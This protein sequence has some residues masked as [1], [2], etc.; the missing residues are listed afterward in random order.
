MTYK[1]FRKRAQPS[2]SAAARPVETE[3]AI[4]TEM[5]RLYPRLGEQLNQGRRAPRLVA[6]NAHPH[7]FRP[8]VPAH[9]R[10]FFWISPASRAV[11]R[12]LVTNYTLSQLLQYDTAITKSW[13]ASTRTTYGGA[14]ADWIRWCDTNS[15]PES[16]RLPINLQDLRMYIADKVGAEGEAKTSNVLAGLQA[17]HTIQ[18]VPWPNGDK[19]LVGL[20]RAVTTNA[21]ASTTR[22]PRPPITTKHL[23]AI[24]AETKRNY[25]P[26]NIATLALACV[27]FWGVCRLGELTIPGN[28][29]P[30]PLHRVRRECRLSVP[31]YL[32]SIP[33]NM[34]FHLPWTKTTRTNGANVNLTE[35][36][37]CVDI[38]PCRTLVCHLRKAWK[39]PP[40]A[41][42]FAYEAPGPQG[43]KALTKDAFMHK[44]RSIWQAANL[45][46]CSGHSFRIGGTTE[47]LMRGVSHD[48]VKLQGR[49]LSD[50]WLRYVREHPQ[51]VQNELT[52]I[53]NTKNIS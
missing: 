38:S 25:T 9:E 2:G 27:A 12:T 21:P 20:R 5:L 6:P 28:S 51:V 1:R 13:A 34:H 44:C 47:L 36:A 26:E 23:R 24:L 14:L 30:E 22:P 4:L 50:A 43:W 42:L 7:P 29:D 8:S 19:L 18:D 45:G 46:D 15:I 33:S 49:W 52:K 10:L 39:L 35:W 48:I 32:Y 16:R 40:S 31:W 41:P 17:W 37:D 53:Q 3:S 11:R